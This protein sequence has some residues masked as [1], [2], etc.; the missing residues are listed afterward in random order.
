MFH[1]KMQVMFSGIS[2]LIDYWWKIHDWV[3]YEAPLRS[4]QWGGH[5]IKTT[6]VAVGPYQI[7]DKLSLQV[8]SI[9]AS[10]APGTL[11]WVHK[12]CLTAYDEIAAVLASPAR[13]LEPFGGLRTFDG[14][15]TG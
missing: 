12:S 2:P 9:R 13:W 6:S 3:W 10:H 7:V 14:I 8:I 15:E 1:A 5:L 11:L 4:Y